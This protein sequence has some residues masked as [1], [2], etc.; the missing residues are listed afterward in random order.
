GGKGTTS[1]TGREGYSAAAAPHHHAARRSA[2][3]RKAG[4]RDREFTGEG[5]RSG[6]QRDVARLRAHALEPGAYR[7]EPIELEPTIGRAVRVGIKGDVRDRVA[8]CGEVRLAGEMP[9][10]HAERPVA[11]LVQAR[12]LRAPRR[13]GRL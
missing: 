9:L 3:R 6:G 2:A 10:H 13:A 4:G 11:A 8:P 12:Q 7:R 1:L 5:G